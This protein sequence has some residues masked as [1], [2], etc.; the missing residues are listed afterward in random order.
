MGLKTL[1][2]VAAAGTL[3]F[4]LGLAGAANAVTCISIPTDTDALPAAGC[5]VGGGS[6]SNFTG[7]TDASSNSAIL[8]TGTTHSIPGSANDS[9]AN[10]E[11]NVEAPL[12]HIFDEFVDLTSSVKLENS[13]TSGDFTIDTT[14]YGGSGF[15]NFTKFDWTY[16]GVDPLAVLT[17]KA[18]NGFII[19]DIEGMTSGTI[20]NTLLVN[21]S[22]SPHGTSHVTF[23]TGDL[24]GGDDGTGGPNPGAVSEPAVLGLAMVGLGGLL[25][26]RRRKA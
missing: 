18:S 21:G 19:F 7:L 13:F 24:P 9:G 5:T 2:A 1:K 6:A 15:G 10:G 23:W 14:P 25:W 3:A 16:T 8:W 12:D 22:G 26:M 20:E 17:L 11:V 4:G